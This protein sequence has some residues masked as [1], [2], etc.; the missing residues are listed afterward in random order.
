[1]TLQD[2]FNTIWQ[3]FIVEGAPRCES[4]ELC[5]YAP[6]GNGTVGCF[7]GCLLPIETAKYFD[8]HW[9]GDSIS[10]LFDKTFIDKHEKVVAPLREFTQQLSELQNIHDLYWKTRRDELILFAKRWGLELNNEP[11]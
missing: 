10:T 5:M 9:L 7:A 2:I 1:M 4:G 8:K 6:I 3:K 11:R